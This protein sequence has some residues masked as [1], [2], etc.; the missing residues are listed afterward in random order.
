MT[1]RNPPPPAGRVCDMN[2]YQSQSTL[3]YIVYT[4]EANERNINTI[5]RLY[6]ELDTQIRRRNQLHYISFRRSPHHT[7]VLPPWHTLST[8][9]DV[10]PVTH[11]YQAHSNSHTTC[12]YNAHRKHQFPPTSVLP[13]LLLLYLPSHRQRHCPTTR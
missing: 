3:A 7:V 11:S 9:T 12:H 10:L 1:F 5:T 13:F 2:G 6:R 4:C 8:I